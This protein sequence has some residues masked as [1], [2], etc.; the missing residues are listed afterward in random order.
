MKW[1][2]AAVQDL[3]T[4][5]CMEQ[6]LENMDERIRALSLMYESL[7]LGGGLHGGEIK[8]SPSGGAEDRLLDNIVE[9]QRLELNLHSTRRLLKLIRRGL[10]ALSEDEKQVLES[11]YIRRTSDYI[12]RLSETL[13]CER[14][15]LYRL[16]DRALYNFTRAMYGITEY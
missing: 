15:T 9:R 3:E 2:Q 1:T 16:K 13:C 8:K 7:Q 14:P 4:Y 12:D 11:F 10:N 5:A 6:S